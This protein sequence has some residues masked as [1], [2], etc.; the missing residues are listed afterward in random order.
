MLNN[1]AHRRLIA[2]M[3]PLVKTN[4]NCVLAFFL[5]VVIVNLSLILKETFALQARKLSRVI[6]RYHL[7]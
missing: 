4:S 2:V 3:K 1:K 7:P 5:S 6:S